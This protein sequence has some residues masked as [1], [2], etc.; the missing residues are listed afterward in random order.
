MNNDNHQESS[1]TSQISLAE[2]N[3]TESMQNLVQLSMPQELEDI[4]K[5]IANSISQSEN[6]ISQ[7]LKDTYQLINSATQQLSGGLSS[8]NTQSE[9]SPL[10]SDSAT[11]HSETP[12]S[13]ADNVLPESN[14]NTTNM[15]QATPNN[16]QNFSQNMSNLAN[17]KLNDELN[18]MTQQMQA[19]IEAVK[20]TIYSAESKLQT[21]LEQVNQ[22]VSQ[23]YNETQTK[24]SEHPAQA[25]QPS[26]KPQ[27]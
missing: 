14:Q 20:N 27:N 25:E 7:T 21:G 3:K 9:V 12:T 4:Q 8:T 13:Q 11:D 18:H 6:V 1:Q 24:Q 17:S 2:K 19:S 22:N 10:P 15:T 23:V 5:S 26:D 16:E